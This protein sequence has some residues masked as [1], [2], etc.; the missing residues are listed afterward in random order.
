MWRGVLVRLYAL[1]LQAHH[2]SVF[3]SL[4]ISVLQQQEPYFRTPLSLLPFLL[5]NSVSTRFHTHHNFSYF[6]GGTQKREK[7][8]PKSLFSLSLAVLFVLRISLGVPQLSVFC[9]AVEAD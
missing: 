5:F 7:A 1:A 8:S 3:F 9:A 4:F 6:I 2:A